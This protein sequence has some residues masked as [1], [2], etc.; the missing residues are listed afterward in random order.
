MMQSDLSEENIHNELWTRFRDGN[1]YTFIGSVL[2]SVN[3]YRKIEKKGKV[4][5][6]EDVASH[7]SKSLSAELCPHI[8]S[9]AG[10]A[11]NHLK[12][13][14]KNQTIV[15]T[16]ESG[17][18]KT[19]AAKSLMSFLT[20]QSSRAVAE[21][22]FNDNGELMDINDEGLRHS[23]IVGD[24]GLTKHEVQEL[25]N[26]MTPAEKLTRALRLM[27]ER[28]AKNNGKKKAHD[29]KMTARDLPPPPR[30]GSTSEDD[31][32]KL[33][34][35]FQSMSRSVNEQGEKTVVV[36]VFERLPHLRDLLRDG[37]VKDDFIKAI[38]AHFN[39]KEGPEWTFAVFKRAL[40]LAEIEVM[41]SDPLRKKSRKFSN[42]Q[43]DDNFVVKME[44]ETNPLKLNALNELKSQLLE[45]NPVL[46]I[47][48]NSKTL[49]NDNSSRFGKY[50]E[51]QFDAGHSLVGGRT[52]TY[53]LEKARIVHQ[54]RGERNFHVLH[55]LNDGTTSDEK[56]KY[57]LLPRAD[58]YQYLLNSDMHDVNFAD[59]AKQLQ[60]LQRSLNKV[61]IPKHKVEDV[62]YLLSAILSIGNLMF[63]EQSEEDENHNSGEPMKIMN[64]DELDKCSALL[65]VDSGA[66]EAALVKHKF[67]Q[68]HDSSYQPSDEAVRPRKVTMA[69][70][71]HS[72]EAA[73]SV[74]D[75][76]AKE[77]Y[78]RL[79]MWIV[80]TINQNIDYTNPQKKTVGILDIYGF[81]IFEMNG[82]EQ[83][84]INWCNEKLQKFFIDQTI[85]AEQKEYDNEGIPW[86]PIDYFDNAVVLTLIE[87]KPGLI[88]LLDD[89]NA[90]LNTNAEKFTQSVEKTLNSKANLITPQ[91]SKI[92]TCRNELMFGINHYAGVVYYSTT[93]FT[94]K[95]NELLVNDLM[96]L[97]VNS[98]S[99]FISKL[100]EDKRTEAEKLKKPPTMG[101]QF[102][103]DLGL[104]VSDLSHCK[105][106]YVRCI[107]PNDTKSASHFDK[108]K[109]RHQI[110]YLGLVE[111]IKV[112]RAGYCYRESFKIFVHRFGMLS[113]LTWSGSDSFG[114]YE[115]K[116]RRILTGGSPTSWKNTAPLQSYELTEN[117]DFR[118][119]MTKVFI[120]EP[121]VVF[122]LERDRR[123]AVHALLA[124]VQALV[125]CYFQR[126]KFILIKQ[127]FI[128]TQARIRCFIEVRRY[129]RT[130]LDLLRLQCLIR[131]FV[132][133]CRYH[134]MRA[135][136]KGIPPRIYAKKLQAIVR[137][138]VT[139]SRMRRKDVAKYCILQKVLH[140]LRHCEVR[141]AAQIMISKQVRGL[142]QRQEFFK[143][144]MAA[145]KLRF[146]MM[147]KIRWIWK[148][149][150]IARDIEE[151][152]AAWRSEDGMKVFKCRANG[153]KAVEK[154]FR[155]AKG[156][157]NVFIWNAGLMSNMRAGVPLHQDTMI[158]KGG[159]TF[160]N[161]DAERET[162]A[163]NIN[164]NPFK[165]ND[166]K[167]QT[168]MNSDVA[169][170]P[171]TP[172]KRSNERESEFKRS[173]MVQR[174]VTI[175]N[176]PD[177]EL[178]M[179]FDTTELRDKIFTVLTRFAK[180]FPSSPSLP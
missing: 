67:Y 64:E 126:K 122:N 89:Q 118:M 159:H 110:K 43:Y 117:V 85:R 134:E 20:F 63:E 111:N 84:C 95:N 139:R 176:P 49:R 160:K 149:R 60:S 154:V 41:H 128:L 45:S 56:E 21:R 88:S 47:F 72:P 44:F 157:D 31:D 121:V 74:K 28:E 156:K 32:A 3:P 1:I 124:R 58:M 57:M 105:P 144:K 48:G 52:T 127:G 82:F 23:N 97:M 171:S 2:I 70:S 141:R 4:I 150:R 164:N 152:V 51:L 145:N 24:A 18:G 78:N 167:L 120:K 38:S 106:H 108:E 142:K 77:I 162:M 15:V 40:Q 98:K 36:T 138:L 143:K 148:E 25:E 61:G 136:F 125:R 19:E 130:L 87:Q 10:D 113:S 91:M 135:R 179:V 94:E 26:L 119:G 169:D 39:E 129:K 46:E 133:R 92:K 112:R 83:F 35:Y 37:I 54:R 93:R 7:Y 147:V 90:T 102:R 158:L 115:E 16:G 165:Q 153:T 27:E 166:L 53:L 96:R 65:C 73:N 80:E 163:L 146:H 170:A 66:L 123:L 140:N 71:Y 99:N 132:M 100:F 178:V 177:Q 104:L 174:S 155:L 116:V 6:S 101:T 76:L 103:K 50:T 114:A 34:S 17:A 33:L 11:Y 86:T 59:A 81:E 12:D 137:S 9:I 62:F 175:A 161:E 107:K 131:R 180:Q 30:S 42:F 109:V 22:H 172:H 55:L 168:M 79:F 14:N 13:Y 69:T 68:G 75:S 151:A 5:Y 8:F 173:E 29:K